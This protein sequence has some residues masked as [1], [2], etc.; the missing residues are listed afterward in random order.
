VLFRGREHGFEDIEGPAVSA[1]EAVPICMPI[2]LF[3]D[4]VRAIS[5]AAA[6]ATKLNSGKFS[7]R[8]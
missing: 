2:V 7:Y 8:R 1:H 5:P 3:R 6:V 4:A